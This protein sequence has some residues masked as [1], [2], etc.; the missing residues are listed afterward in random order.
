M[1]NWLVGLI[2]TGLIVIGVLWAFSKS[3]PF[4]PSYEVKAVFESAQNLAPNSQV[5]IAGVQVG[6]VTGVEPLAGAD[7]AEG[8][9]TDN[10]VGAVVTMEIKDSGRPIRE[11]SAFQLRPRL[12][13]EGNLFVELRPGSPSSPEVPDGHVF[14][15]SQT[16]YSVQLDQVLTTLQS[17]VREDLQ[18]L[19]AEFGT[20]LDDEG[21]SEG[22]RELFRTSPEAFRTTA[23]VNE[24]FL[25]VEPH[26]VSELIG[27]LDRVVGALAQ[28]EEALKGAV[29]N[30]DTFLGSLAAEN[31][32]LRSAVAQ[33]PGVLAVGRPA[34]ARLNAALPSLRAFSREAL[35]GARTAREALL[36]GIPLARQLSRWSRPSELRG[37][38]GNLRGA[39]PEL[40]RLNK[41]TIPFLEQARALASCSNNV[42]I[43]F[44][45]MSVP[46]AP[47]YPY[48]AAGT[49]AEELGYGLVGIAGESRGGDAN[50]QIIRVGGGGG[51][52]T[53]EYSTALGET[54]A[55]VSPF[56]ILGA[57]PMISA[58]AKTPFRPDQPCE[59]QELPNLASA[60]GAGPTQTTVSPDA[61]ATGTAGKI[62]AR[63]EELLGF[64]EKAE[65]LRKSGA[66][67]AADEL[68]ERYV[69]G[70]RQLRTGKGF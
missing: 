47:G 64:M 27:H 59:N 7:E 54:L 33:L 58:S 43:P 28:N 13:L 66:V 12:F 23:Q 45:N 19:L 61:K 42:V 55:G 2:V 26:D 35:P 5:R 4:T 50:G 11:D 38:A 18:V 51:T 24:A 10:G 52:N 37:L 53:I 48:P 8:A 21:G 65:K 1:P 39:T 32:A 41:R 20:A 16:S 3:I 40:Y 63:A 70:A 17:D 69:R 46:S 49:I 68:V 29:T 44:N 30:L 62:V 36:A 14:N 22:F 6:K 31:Q 34:L 56:P 57:M 15:T 9:G 60:V 25:G 67:E